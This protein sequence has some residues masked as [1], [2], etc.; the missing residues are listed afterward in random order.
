MDNIPL[1][2]VVNITAG[3]REP[4]ATITMEPFFPGYGMTIGN[5]L[6][7]VMLSS[8]PGAAITAFS[9]KG[10]AH[11][12]STLPHVKEDVVEI[13]LNL[14]QVRLRVHGGEPVRV[15]L[16]ARGERKVT[17][18]DLTP[19]SAVEIVNP[20]QLIATLTDEAAALDLELIASPG[21]GYLAT[22]ARERET[23]EVGMIALDALYSPVR[24]VGFQVENVRVGQMT[25]WDKLILEMET[26]GSI[27][28][29][30]AVELAIRY[31]NDH[32]TAI[33]GKLAE[34]AAAPADRTADAAPPADA[35]ANA[36][37]AA[38]D[39]AEEV[40][41]EPAAELKPKRQ[42]KKSD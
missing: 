41:A 35:P 8:L 16:Q 36:S 23:L 10:V 28:P 6:R 39:A 15:K 18:G 37:G 42:A 7:R 22:E 12:F 34:P 40:P 13:S 38:A 11:E 29:C 19:S 9:V 21:R 2:S 1:P 33:A 24:K 17:A 30:E 32:L 31:L 4:R 25:N 5:A 14:K 26:D 3:E 20:Q 27:T